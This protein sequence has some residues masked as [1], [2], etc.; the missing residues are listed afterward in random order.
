M[1]KPQ[2]KTKEIGHNICVSADIK[3]SEN[4]GRAFVYFF[5]LKICQN[6]LIKISINKIRI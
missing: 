1:Q 6:S 5:V 2:V 3:P 4:V